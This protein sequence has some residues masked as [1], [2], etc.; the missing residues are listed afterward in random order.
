MNKSVSIYIPFYRGG[1]YLREAVESVRKQTSPHWTLHI[2]DDCGPEGDAARAWVE[3]LGDL[4]ISYFRHPK[5]L[6][7][8]GNWNS[9][10]NHAAQ[11]GAP[12]VTLLHDDDRLLPHYVELMLAQANKAPEAALFFC[13]AK[14]IDPTGKPVFSFPDVIKKFIAPRTTA[15]ELHGEEALALLLKG[16]FIMCPTVCYNL[17]VVGTRRFSEGFKQVQDLEF[18]LRLLLDGLMLSGT[19]EVAYEYRRHPNNATAQQTAS[20][21]RFEEEV[22]LY[23]SW[24]ATLSR[25]GLAAASGVARSKTIIKLNLLYCITRDLLSL[26]PARA[27]TKARFLLGRVLF[28]RSNIPLESPLT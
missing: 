14:I 13:G 2:M 3:G 20:L 28:S 26:S 5:N 11:A 6:G 21:L 18:Y 27:A 23:S 8:V 4:R 1:E 25:A 19:A 15:Y 7:M 9:C 12:L 22:S 16:C 24:D 10:L 17:P